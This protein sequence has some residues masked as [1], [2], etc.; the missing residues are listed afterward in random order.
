M[1]F[2]N[3]VQG[4]QRGRFTNPPFQKEVGQ[5][6]KLRR[7]IRLNQK[8]KIQDSYRGTSWIQKPRFLLKNHI[9]VKMPLSQ[10]DVSTRHQV[11]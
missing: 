4:C 10:T 8:T 1:S 7:Q 5:S 9:I 6:S 3:N 11:I 2:G